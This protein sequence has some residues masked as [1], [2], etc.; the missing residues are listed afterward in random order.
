MLMRN[1]N[2]KR[3]QKANI[4][5]RLVV[6]WAGVGGGGG[7]ALGLVQGRPVKYCWAK[8]LNKCSPVLMN[9]DSN[10]ELGTHFSPAFM[11][12]KDSNRKQPSSESPLKPRILP[13]PSSLSAF[14]AAPTA[15]RVPKTKA[16]RWNG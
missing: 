2:W 7:I 4:T 14:D 13:S 11:F 10:E 16:M 1:N 12:T 8:E 15:I 9:A 5:F 3:T 6:T